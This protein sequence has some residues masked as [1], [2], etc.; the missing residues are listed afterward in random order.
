MQADEIYA[1]EYSQCDLTIPDNCT[2]R[3]SDSGRYI[4]ASAD[5]DGDGILDKAYLAVTPD[6]KKS[7]LIAEVSS[8]NGRFI[9]R[10]ENDISAVFYMG[11]TFQESGDGNILTACGKGYWECGKD[12]PSKIQL[13]FS[14]ID[15]FMYGSSNSY[16]IWNSER[17][18]FDRVWISD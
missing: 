11:V 14:A 16:F 13:K 18:E 12:E 4:V 7:A 2:W 17:H 8:K 1:I 10:E 3:N 5:F 6:L 9:L 15:Y